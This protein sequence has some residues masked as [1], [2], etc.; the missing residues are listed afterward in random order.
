MRTITSLSQVRKGVFHFFTWGNPRRPTFDLHLQTK[1]RLILKAL[2]IP[3]NQGHKNIVK[4]NV[5][6]IVTLI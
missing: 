3:N 2:K 6:D 5:R 4:Y 1:Q